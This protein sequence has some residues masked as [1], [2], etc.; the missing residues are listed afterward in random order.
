M[1]EATFVAAA[2]YDVSQTDLEFVDEY[3]RAAPFWHHYRG[4][5]RY[6]RKK[7]ERAEP[8]NAIP[9]AD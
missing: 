8:T 7:G 6:W 3:D 5:E 4:I 2:R 9:A 1:D